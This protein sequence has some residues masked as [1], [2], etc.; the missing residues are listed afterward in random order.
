MRPLRPHNFIVA[1]LFLALFTSAGL[2][3][4]SRPGG[5][6][7]ADLQSEMPADSKQLKIGDTPPDFSLPGIDGKQHS[8][9]LSYQL[10]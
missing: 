4:Q 2:F 1:S 3:A 8:Y 6:K 7:G 9:E 5:G 10:P